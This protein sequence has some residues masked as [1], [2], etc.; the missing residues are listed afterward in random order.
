MKFKQFLVEG[1]KE[2]IIV[3]LNGMSDSE[4]QEFGQWVYGVLFEY[5]GDDED[6]T[7]ESNDNITKEEI[8]ELLG[9]M[10]SEELEYISDMLSIEDEEDLDSHDH[11]NDNIEESVSRR[12]ASKNRNKKTNTK[13]HNND[14]RPHNRHN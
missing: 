13:Q 4:I 6:V 2:D 8:I 10:N 1:V 5:D 9:D 7:N 11:N 14:S 3:V 12:L